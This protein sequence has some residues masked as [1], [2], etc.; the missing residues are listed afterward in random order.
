[1]I[2]HADKAVELVRSRFADQLLRVTAHAGQTTVDVRRDKIHDLLK[3]LRDD[4][5]FDFLQDVA[6]LDYLNLEQPE[7]FAVAYH[8]YSYREKAIIRVKA[9]VPEEDPTIDSASDLW[10]AANWAEREAFDM[11]GIRFKGHPALKRILMPDAYEGH[12][13]RKDYPLTGRGE[14][15]NFPKYAAPPKP[16]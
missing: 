12:P 8:L 5:G 14:R 11:F 3:A 7:R 6:G 1:M 4:L 9:W 13:L 15:M 16:E 10:L 2:T